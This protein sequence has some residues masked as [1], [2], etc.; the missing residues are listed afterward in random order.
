[1][2]ASS[3]K[4]KMWE[5]KVFAPPMESTRTLTKVCTLPEVHTMLCGP[6]I[7]LPQRSLATLL[8]HLTTTR[9][10]MTAVASYTPRGR[11]PYR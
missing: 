5:I 11:N 4:N 6:R 9:G 7:A 2:A 3:G 1:M 10:L 8:P